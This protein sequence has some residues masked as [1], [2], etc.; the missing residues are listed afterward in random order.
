MQGQG[1]RCHHVKTWLN[2]SPG[3]GQSKFQKIFMVSSQLSL[4][5]CPTE[6]AA[7]LRN[8]EEGT[9]SAQ[10]PTQKPLSY[11]ITRETVGMTT[12]TFRAPQQPSHIRL[13]PYHYEQLLGE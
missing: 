4:L 10:K 12:V 7:A 6:Q 5:Y 2:G 11:M 3:P 8:H 1:A 9:L 13:T